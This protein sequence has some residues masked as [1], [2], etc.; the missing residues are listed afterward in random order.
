[1]VAESKDHQGKKL[2]TEEIH[3]LT[4][5]NITEYDMILECAWALENDS[6][7]ALVEA[8]GVRIGVQYGNRLL[9]DLENM[10]VF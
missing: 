2:I 9:I 5:E 7:T 1:M 6:A 8:G 4:P 3:P 10:K